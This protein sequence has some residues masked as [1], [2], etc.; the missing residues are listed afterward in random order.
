MLVKLRQK[1][2]T[3]DMTATQA[4]VKQMTKKMKGND[5]TL[6]VY[7]F[8][9]PQKLNDCDSRPNHMEMPENFGRQENGRGQLS[10]TYGW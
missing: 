2:A 5:H 10:G 7:N 1:C 3:P 9:S 8:S 6:C 4:T